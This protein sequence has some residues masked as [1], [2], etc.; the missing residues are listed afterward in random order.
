MLK[1]SDVCVLI[2]DDEEDI[3]EA[4]TS[5]LELEGFQILTASSGNEAI[6][7]LKTKTPHFI[8]S[9]IRMPRGDG[10]T[11]LKYVRDNFKVTP[12]IVLFSGFA[13][14]TQEEVRALGGLALVSKPPNLDELI[15]LIKKT[16]NCE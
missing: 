7:L 11:L 8:I 5:N 2:V 1:T 4:M 16:C 14:I 13:E 12:H 6:E 9:D 15:E 3:R 10:V